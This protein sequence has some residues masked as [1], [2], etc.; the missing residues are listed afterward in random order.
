MCKTFEMFQKGLLGMRS[1][2]VPQQPSMQTSDEVRVKQGNTLL[3]VRLYL[4][5]CNWSL[6]IAKCFD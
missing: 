6:V 3:M 1:S 5:A 4:V 2:S